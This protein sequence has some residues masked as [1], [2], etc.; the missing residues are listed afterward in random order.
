MNAEQSNTSQAVN[1]SESNNNYPTD[2][3]VAQIFS[4]AKARRKGEEIRC[5]ILNQDATRT[6]AVRAEE[7]RTGSANEGTRKPSTN[8]WRK[9]VS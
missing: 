9:R 3:P 4:K 6:G 8:Y 1:D 5:W 7:A 2:N